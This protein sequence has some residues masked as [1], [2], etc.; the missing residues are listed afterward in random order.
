MK[1]W[2]YLIVTFTVIY[3]SVA[4]SEDDPVNIDNNFVN[5][6]EEVQ[7]PL[8]AYLKFPLDRSG[9]SYKYSKVPLPIC[10]PFS[11]RDNDG[12]CMKIVGMQ[13]ICPKNLV[14]EDDDGLL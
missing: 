12:N 9:C 13:I 5:S 4:L 7:Q 14:K 2:I 6:S 8:G 1:R 3:L 11:R 10:T